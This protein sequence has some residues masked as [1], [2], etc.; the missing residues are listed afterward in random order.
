MLINSQDSV[1]FCDETEFYLS[2]PLFIAYMLYG[3]CRNIKHILLR[4]LRCC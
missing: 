4:V 2:Y 1:M 3:P